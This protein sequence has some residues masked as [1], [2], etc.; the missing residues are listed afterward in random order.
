MFRIIHRLLI[1]RPLHNREMIHEKL[2]KWKAL[3]IFSSDPLSSVGYGPEQIVIVL[4]V[5]GLLAYGYFP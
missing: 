4:A 1:G 5:P 2:P 3:S